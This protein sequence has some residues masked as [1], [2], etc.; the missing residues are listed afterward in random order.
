MSRQ[1]T[2][3]LPLLA[4]IL[5][6]RFPLS[7]F[8][9]SCYP[10]RMTGRTKSKFC[11]PAVVLV[12]FSAV[13]PIRALACTGDCDGGG[14]VGIS[15]II[16]GVNIALE[17]ADV[18]TCEAADPSGD[19]KVAINELVQAVHSSLLGCGDDNASIA[20]PFRRLSQ[21]EYARTLQDL[22]LIPADAAMGLAQSLPPE[23]D[24]G[25]FDT[26]VESQGISGLH[27][28]SYLE[29]GTRA[30]DAAIEVGESP[31]LASH[32]IDYSKGY[33]LLIGNGT[34]FGGGVIVNNDDAAVLFHD[35]TCTY[36]LDSERN[37]YRV[38]RAG[39][40]R[41]TMEI[42]RHRGVS[43][44]VATLFRGKTQGVVASLDEL[45]GSWDLTDDN[46]RVVQTTTYLEPGDLLAPCVSEI[47]SPPG[48][49]IY[50]YLAEDKFAN[51]GFLG[52][53]VA[54]RT[55]TI[56]PVVDRWPPTST[57]SLLTGVDFDEAGEIVL[58]KAPEQHLGEIVANFARRAF[59]RPV[60]AD[61]IARI[62]PLG[63]NVLN[64]GRPFVDAVKVSLSAILSSPEFLYQAADDQMLSDYE[65]ATRLAY[66]LWRSPPDVQLLSA[67]ER[68]TLSDP[69]ELDR[70]AERMLVDAKS[71]RFV[72][73]FVAQAY[74]LNELQR[75]TPSF[76]LGYNE[77]VGRAMKLE[78]ELFIATLID[79]NLG[80]ANLIDSDFTFVNR[81]LATL[82]Q[83]EEIEGQQMRRISL[84]P[85]SI[86]GGLLTQGSIL[87]ITANGTSTSP[88]P[89]GNFVLDNLLGTPV[90]PPP[91]G[92]T[93]LEPDTRGTT[94]I[95]EQLAAHRT[96][97][98]CNT[99]HS[100]IDPPGFAL[101]SF[102][103]AG[104][105]RINYRPGIPVDSSG[106]T[107]SGR[108]FDGIEEYKQILFDEE[109]DQV[110]RA[111]ITKLLVLATGE[112]LSFDE[113][114]EVE[115]ILDRFRGDGYPMRS[116][117]RA[118]VTSS[119]FGRRS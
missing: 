45:I 24:S 38:P 103:P 23:A 114:D 56:E 19:G 79:E 65:L 87:K 31:P 94:T 22:L 54:F 66:F 91:P 39:D 44:V 33:P 10:S 104:R 63:E 34:F 119:A 116:L 118:V 111:F 41:V 96:E 74:R 98:V 11:L 52:E 83:M 35:S 46:P 106:V 61:E 88:V 109:L 72:V 62:T 37:G 85:D 51:D 115:E 71:L 16:R 95:R 60:R 8:V 97:P 20:T 48:D 49:N 4:T 26:F 90:P 29:A 28:R 89:R 58:N 81:A 67:A 32:I 7:I 64:E 78:T 93:G 117:I 50:N 30:L 6:N 13:A 76:S 17:R 57:R 70:Q 43:T 5:L 75:T 80:I 15:E 47:N 53:G 101:E 25:G 86:R 99:C 107:L 55:L 3:R 18:S 105:F 21:L 59:R 9:S 14:S 102:N 92:V 112:D 1:G 42:Y 110:A 73:D 113:Q 100:A 77:R 69:L 68:M 12:L 108:S 84:S 2:A 27:I 36:A 40:Y 82:Y